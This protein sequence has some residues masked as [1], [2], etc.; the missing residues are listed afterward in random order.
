MIPANPH[1]FFMRFFKKTGVYIQI[2]TIKH[3]FFSKILVWLVCSSL[4][5][6]SFR[7]K[8]AQKLM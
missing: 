7:E 1:Q 3:Q 2:M 6:I 5:H 8:T 4:S